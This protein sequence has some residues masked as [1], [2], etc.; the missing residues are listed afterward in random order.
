ALRA[1]TL[2]A[3]DI[4]GVADTFGS[5]E[6]GKSATLIVTTGH[7]L[8]VL[9]NVELAFINGRAIDLENKQT[10]LADKYR[11]KYQQLGIISR[12]D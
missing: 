10:K 4:F 7:P 1:L 6:T 11:E 3:A 2:C 12:D 5:L 9:S 8:D